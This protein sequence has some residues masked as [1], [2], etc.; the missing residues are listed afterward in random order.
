MLYSL[1]ISFIDTFSF[2]NVFKYLTVRTGLSMFTAMLV[3]FIVGTPFI[4]YFSKKQILFP[5]AATGRFLKN[6]SV[7]ATGSVF[8]FSKTLT[9]IDVCFVVPEALFTPL[10][11]P[12]GLLGGAIR[13]SG[14]PESPPW[15]A[16]KNQKHPPG[17][18]LG[19]PKSL[20]R[21]SERFLNC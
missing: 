17:A 12:S 10:W 20:Q 2:L 1:L 16:R 4:N 8:F 7:V 19:G 5:L 3:V 18:P 15:A 21:A 11:T 9:W 14:V 13:N 6:V